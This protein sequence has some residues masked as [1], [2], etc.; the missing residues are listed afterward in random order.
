MK[1]KILQ[2][3]VKGKELSPQVAKEIA[4]WLADAELKKYKKRIENLISEKKWDILMDAFYKFVIF[5]TGGIRGVMDAGINRVN[6]FT[7]GLASQAFANYLNKFKKASLKNGVII[8]YDTR[9]NSKDFA[10]L[11]ASVLA[12]NNI[13]VHIFSYYRPTPELSFAIREMKAVGG[14]IVTASHNPPQFNGYKLYREDGVQTLPNE[15]IKIEKEF[16]KIKKIKKISFNAGKDQGL[17]KYIPKRIDEKFLAQAKK[18][19]LFSKRNIRIVYSP[20]HGVG[21][22]SVLPVLKTLGFKNIDVVKEQMTI[23]GNFSTVPNFFPQPEFPIVY[24]KAIKLA[25]KVKA[26]IILLS[27]PDADRLGMAIPDDKNGWIPL[28]GN[29]GA[30]LML[31][32]I[33]E[34][35][36]KSGK[37][38]K[39]G[40]VI[41]TSVTTELMRDIAEKYG[42]E[43]IG[44]LLVGFK[45]IGDRIEKLPPKKTFIFAAEESIGYLYGN[46]YRDKGSENAAVIASEMT[47][48]CKQL[49][50]TPLKLL[51]NIYQEYGFYSERLFYQ[52][53]KGMGAFDQMTNAMKALRKKLPREISGKK[54]LK[55]IDRLSGEVIDPSTGKIV[56]KRNWDKGDMLTFIFTPDERTVIH[57]RPSGTEPKVKYYTNV[58]GD[59]SSIS[60]EKIQKES[61]ILEK[62]IVSLFG[63]ILKETKN[64][65]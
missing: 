48:Y 9:N 19:S 7:I 57:L 32:F 62:G 24:D 15:A 30:I 3:A 28:N 16:K 65:P 12:A 56:E 64:S 1:E 54:V 18:L 51:N 59:L 17:I 45:F 46:S 44:D 10:E 14:I 63:K 22:Q 25:K 60:K 37:L 40:V 31:N 43:V 29:Q 27:D 4:R 42:I 33:L 39:H 35:L 38:S 55:I 61:A 50:T 11:T 52:E 21:S 36:K 6:D 23:D 41:K 20:L 5:G 58:K 2:E 47:A 49:K 13:P 8:A 26:D 53:I 34:S